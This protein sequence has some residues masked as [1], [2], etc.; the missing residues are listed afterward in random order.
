MCAMIL[1][2]DNKLDYDQNVKD[3]VPDFP[4]DN[5]TVRHL[6]THTS[7]LPE[8]FEYYEN[9]FPKNKILTNSSFSKG[10]EFREK[11]NA[12]LELYE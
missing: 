10:K 8:Y 9:Y 12:I 7:G 2:E 5:I 3:D 1:N 6:M 4:Y 11:V